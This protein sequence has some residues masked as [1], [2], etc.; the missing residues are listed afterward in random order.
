MSAGSRRPVMTDGRTGPAPSPL[1]TGLAARCPRCGEGRL[2]EKVLEVRAR[3][4]VCGLD[5]TNHDSGDGP[6]V[7]V[8]LVL[9]AVVVG[10]A[11]ALE[12]AFTPPMWVHAAV[13]IPVISGLSILLLRLFK[14]VLIA[15]HYRNLRHE[16]GDDS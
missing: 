12:V 4:D 16:Y 9:G 11:L 1:A 15:L 8:I 7:F 6:A 14:G 5:L 13:W 2:L 3:C 10:L